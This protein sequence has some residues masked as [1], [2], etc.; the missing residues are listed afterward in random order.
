MVSSIKITKLI[1]DKSSAHNDY[2]VSVTNNEAS[3]PLNIIFRMVV[4]KDNRNAAN[5][6]PRLTSLMS[7]AAE[8]KKEPHV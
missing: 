7:A 8:G 5:H 3:R 1:I 4:S 6:K 2:I